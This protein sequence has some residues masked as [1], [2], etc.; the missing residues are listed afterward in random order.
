MDEQLDRFK[1]AR[2]KLQGSQVGEIA[3]VIF[4]RNK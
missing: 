4:G 3:M 2:E 1:N